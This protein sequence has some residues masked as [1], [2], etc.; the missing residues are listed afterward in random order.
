MEILTFIYYLFLI[1]WYIATIA[2]IIYLYNHNY[3]PYPIQ[4]KE[5]YYQELPSDLNPAEI[6]MLIY[7]RIETEV[8]TAMLLG[9]IKKGALELKQEDGNYIFTIVLSGRKN[10]TR[11]E[12]VILDFLPSLAKMGSFTLTDFANYCGTKRGDSE[13]LFQYDVWK[14]VARREASRKKFYEEKKGYSMI[15][16]MKSLGIVLFIVNIAGGYHLITGYGTLLPVLFIPFF[17]AILY[18]RTEHYSEEYEKWLAFKD[19]LNHLKEFKEPFD[20]NSFTM[21]AIVL[22]RIDKLLEYKSNDKSIAFAYE[23]NKTVLKCYRHAYLKGNR[24]ITSLWN[25]K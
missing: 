21:S 11:S 23:L 18:K 5:R 9:L 19:Y 3:K 13:F 24:S 7:H 16:L 8:F 10:L 15:K 20:I 2:L 17:F 12:T 14:T 25:S 4:Y 6:S 1:I 22:K